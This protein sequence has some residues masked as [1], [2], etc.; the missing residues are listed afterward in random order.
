[1]LLVTGITG[2]TGKFF[3]QN[4]VNNEYK[5]S[6][7][8]VIRN[9]SNTSFMENS[10]LKIEKVIGNLEDEKF[11]D[12]V[13]H[14]VETVIHIYNIHHS[15]IIVKS[16]INSKVKRVILVHTTGIYSQ[17]KYASEGYKQIEKQID[18]YK[19]YS[20]CPSITIV[21][22]SM[23][24]GDLCDK[25]MSVFIKLVDKFR[26]IP[27]INGGSNLIQPVNARDLAKALYEIL[28]NERTVGR[29]YVISGDRPIKMIEVL[30]LISDELSKKTIFINVPLNMGVFMARLLRI[31]SFG[32]VDFIEKVQRMGENRSYSHKNAFD[33]FGYIP[34]K[35][36]DGIKKQVQEY[37]KKNNFSN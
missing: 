23:I 7:R 20:N 24:Y 21:R 31:L 19:S 22:P 34:I 17:F 5:G 4:L 29:D 2:H 12:S 8:C 1:M 37:K 3:F 30:K 16:A 33:D 18:S 26:V 35:F 6:I 15:P 14:G 11:I 25:N 36:E 27:I 32:R 13:M 9:T 10:Q 28:N